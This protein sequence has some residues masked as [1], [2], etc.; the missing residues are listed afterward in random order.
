MTDAERDESLRLFGHRPAEQ[1]EAR[2]WLQPWRRD[3]KRK[4]PEIKDLPVYDKVFQKFVEAMRWLQPWLRGTKA[5]Q[6]N[7]G[8]LSVC[9]ELLQKLVEAMLLETRLAGLARAPLILA[10]HPAMTAPAFGLG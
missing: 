3:T 8:E 5:K 1:G 2:R 6:P 10:L 4:P 9:D 7:V